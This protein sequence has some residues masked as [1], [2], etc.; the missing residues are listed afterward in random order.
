MKVGGDDLS[1]SF[2]VPY[3]GCGSKPSCVICASIDNT[4]VIQADAEV[5]SEWDTARKVSCSRTGIEE[6]KMI[7]FKPF[8]VDMLEVVNVPTK[9]G[10][11]DCW[12]DIKQGR[13]PRNTPIGDSIKIGEDLTVLVYLRDD[14]HEYDLIVRNCW[15]FDNEFYDDKATGKLQLSNEDGCSRCVLQKLEKLI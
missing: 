11:V 3:K 5:Q 2:I 13:Y 8:I 10:G 9:T 14:T 4:L 6:D 7:I 12:M 1:Y 15:A